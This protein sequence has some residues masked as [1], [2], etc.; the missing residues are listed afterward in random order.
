MFT[1]FANRTGRRRQA[2]ELYGAVVAQARNPGFYRALGVAD[3]QDGRYELVA[4]HLVVLIERL[5]R[6]DI[7]D[8]PLR[9][10]TLEAFVTDMDDSMR[11]MG[12][13]DAS[14]PRKVKKAA[15][16]V[17]ERARIYS[18]ALAHA[19][20]GALEAALGLH[21]YRAQPNSGIAPLA[22]YVRATSVHLAAQSATR[23]KAGV[24]TFPS[25][26]A[27]P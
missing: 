27:T 1:W 18:E 20:D 22:R 24:V 4:L 7:G 15:A 23:L 11:E 25:L 5:G 9:R 8:A 2:R 13:S 14:V 17:Y 3:T 26:E 10:E 21:V 19:D 12:V 16:G 6:P